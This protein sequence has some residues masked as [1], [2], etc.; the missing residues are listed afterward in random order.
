MGQTAQKLALPSI[1]ALYDVQRAT[2]WVEA[3]IVVLGG[4]LVSWLLI[5]RLVSFVTR[6]NRLKGFGS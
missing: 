4:V 2:I 6:G 3:L 5:P 1:T